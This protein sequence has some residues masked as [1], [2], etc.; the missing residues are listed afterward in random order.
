MKPIQTVTITGMTLSGFKCFADDTE[1]AFGPQTAVTGGNGRGKSSIADAIAFAFTGLPFFGERGND[2][3][4]SE[5]G[6]GLSVTLRFLDE[7]GLPH[8][9][10]R[11]WDKS[12]SGID[13][14]GN[15]V[16]QTDMVDLF[17]EKDVFLSI[18]NPLYFIEELGNDGRKLLERYLPAI[19]QETVLPLL[20]EQTRT[21]LESE[22]I[23]STEG[24]LSKLREEIRG[25]EQSVVYKTGQKE[26]A[27]SQRQQAEEKVRELTERL[28]A[29]EQERNTLEA[30]RFEGIDL[31]SA[32]E[33]LVDL[34]A[35]YEEMAKEIPGAGDTDAV[36]N[37]LRELREKLAVRTA[38]QYAPKYAEQIAE[39]SAKV[40][41]IGARYKREAGL[42][43]GFQVGTVCPMCRRSVT[44][45]ELPAIQGTLRQSV[46]AIVAEGKDAAAKLDDLKALEQRTEEVFQRFKAEDTEKL[47]GEIR[48]LTARR[49]ALEAA[50]AASREQR[51]TD[52]E[53]L[54][55]EIR[56]LSTLTECGNLTP[57][58]SE[59][60]ALCTDELKTC[61]AELSAAR[62][63]AESGAGD[64]DMELHVLRDQI[65]EKKKLLNAVAQYASKRAELLFS[66]LEMNRVKIS[67]YDV[68]KSPGDVRGRRYDRLSL[69]EK[70]RA[71]MEVSELIKRL[72]GRNYPQFIDNMESVDDLA[73]VRPTGQ[74]I[75][76]KCVRGTALSVRALGPSGA[77][78]RKAA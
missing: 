32:K 10:T 16:R 38:E 57:E 75:M 64:Y 74:V 11:S 21:L 58:E 44:E 43:K 6:K 9:L 72:T 18:F 28:S 15:Q 31:D 68:V 26:L 53:T 46:S 78:A 2:R 59:R 1:I 69:S 60:L 40:K 52:M 77:E 65:D 61:K 33:R 13:Y 36:D 47:N 49:G 41:E 29:L 19:S 25:L 27:A 45:Q 7:N 51:R 5:Q 48:L 67:L 35:R 56:G 39:F 55:T 54:L 12:H 8:T 63:A 30:R 20:S 22:R 73:N 62:S 76:A 66:K 4:V 42:L 50:A 3:L 37:Q 17:G 70:I 24:F 14:D 34:S 23:L 71:G